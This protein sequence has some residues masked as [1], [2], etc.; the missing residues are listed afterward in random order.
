MEHQGMELRKDLCAHRCLC[1]FPRLWLNFRFGM[2]ARAAAAAPPAAGTRRALR[3]CVM[4]PKPVQRGHG[5]ALLYA[6]RARSKRGLGSAATFPGKSY[7]KSSG[8]PGAPASRCFTLCRRKARSPSCYG[9]RSRSTRTQCYFW[10]LTHAAG[11]IRGLHAAS[12]ALTGGVERA[13]GMEPAV[14]LQG[15]LSL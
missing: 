7:E 4:A 8:F 15:V 2:P 12:I 14:D 1:S 9:G 5:A 6:W 11:T 3:G 13:G 10:A